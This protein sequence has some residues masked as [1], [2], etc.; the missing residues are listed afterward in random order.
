MYC[1]KAVICL[2]L[3]LVIALFASCGGS[4]AIPANGTSVQDAIAELDAMHA[5]QGADAAV[6]A[7]LKDALR[8]ALLSRGN[9]KLVATP[10]TGTENA[11]PDLVI[12]DNGNGTFNYAW[13][14]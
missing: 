2:S 5:P 11:I 10:P 7:S 14:Y 6:F 3:L 1:A 4:P 9:G 13:H 8:D 12:T